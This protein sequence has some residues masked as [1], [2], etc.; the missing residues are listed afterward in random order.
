MSDQQSFV[1][2]DRFDRDQFTNSQS[3]E[4]ALNAAIVRA[5][6][7]RSFEEY[8]EI[9]DAFY[10]DDIELSSD[11]GEQAIWGKAEVRSV[12]LRF[13]VPLHIMAEVGGLS[14]SIREAPIP[15]DAAGETH[16]AW[17]LDLVGASGKTATLS[18]STLRTWSGSQVV[19]EHHYDH[20]QSGGPLTFDDWR[21][22]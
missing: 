2:A 12:L 20:L 10:A 4:R 5:E 18:W 16:S 19:H 13:L 3:G 8:L 7:S 15:S 22:K 11:T 1:P 6:I 9:F 17:T 14:I 21:L